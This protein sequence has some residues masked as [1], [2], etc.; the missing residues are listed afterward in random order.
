MV[1]IESHRGGKLCGSCP[2]YKQWSWTIF[3]PDD[4]TLRSGGTALSPHMA[5][6]MLTP[7]ENQYCI[8]LAD[9]WL[10]ISKDRKSEQANDNV[11]VHRISAADAGRGGGREHKLIKSAS[12]HAPPNGYFDC[13]VEV[14]LNFVDKY[15]EGTQLTL[16]HRCYT[17]I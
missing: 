15:R 6:P 12:P 10:E 5:Q 16:R 11:V 7:Q 14:D 4:G 2:S 9:W 13:T 8:R 17:V 1:Q 3:H